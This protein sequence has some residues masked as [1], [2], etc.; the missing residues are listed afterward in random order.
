MPWLPTNC[1][2]VVAA[3][4]AWRLLNRSLF[5]KPVVVANGLTLPVPPTKLTVAPVLRARL[6]PVSVEEAFV[7]GAA[8]K[9]ALIVD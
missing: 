2:A 4:F 9:P 8:V 6:V 7:A 1:K 3:G 5:V